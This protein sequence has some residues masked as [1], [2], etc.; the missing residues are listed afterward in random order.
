ME[1]AVKNAADPK[2]VKN[3]GRVARFIRDK[4]LDDMR[5]VLKLPAGRRLLWKYLGICGVFRTSFTGNSYTFFNEGARNV[6]LQLMTDITEAD[7]DSYLTMMKEAQAEEKANNA[8]MR[9][10][11]NSDDESEDETEE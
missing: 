7:A 3:A 11:E 8:Q 1:A 4:E 5:A 2:Q 10:T 9:S 6:G